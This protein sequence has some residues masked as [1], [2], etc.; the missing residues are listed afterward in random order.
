MAKTRGEVSPRG[1]RRDVW[2]GD[3]VVGQDPG[4]TPGIRNRWAS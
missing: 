1:P 2:R 3:A 4:R